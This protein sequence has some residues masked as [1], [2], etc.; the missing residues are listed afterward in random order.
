[1]LENIHKHFAPGGRGG[2]YV[3]AW[4]TSVESNIVTDD[5][6]EILNNDANFFFWLLKM[7]FERR[8]QTIET[9]GL[10]IHHLQIKWNEK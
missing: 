7:R 2:W 10:Q 4:S 5:A 9:Q 1:V 6:V 8:V 3:N